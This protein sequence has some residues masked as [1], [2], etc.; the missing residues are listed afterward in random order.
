MAAEMDGDRRQR[1]SAIVGAFG[2]EGR[3]GTRSALWE[4]KREIVCFSSPAESV[5]A[6]NVNS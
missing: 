1:E 5:I 6:M 4:Q 3:R 2:G